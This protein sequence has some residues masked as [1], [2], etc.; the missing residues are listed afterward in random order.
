MLKNSVA[1][2]GDGESDEVD[3][4]ILV[5]H[6]SREVV[7][8]ALRDLRVVPEP[9]D[10]GGREGLDLALQVELVAL[11]PRARLAEEGGLDPALDPGRRN[12]QVKR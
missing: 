3:V 5:G 10:L 6:V 7:A 1:T 4:G 2:Y 11:L 12:E 8:V 9:P